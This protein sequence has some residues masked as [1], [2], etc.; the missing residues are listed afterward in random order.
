MFNAIAEVM[1]ICVLCA[2]RCLILTPRT[3]SFPSKIH[4]PKI[5]V[6]MCVG[7]RLRLFI[8]NKNLFFAKDKERSCIGNGIIT[9]AVARC[10]DWDALYTRHLGSTHS[11]YSFT[12]SIALVCIQHYYFHDVPSAGRKTNKRKI[13]GRKTIEDRRHRH[14][15][16]VR[17]AQRTIDDF[18]KNA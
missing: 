4:S 12:L 10:L 5:V 2:P 13:D 18:G 6:V 17:Q 9:V 8:Q 16:A 3:R 15:K 1:L 7:A 11:L 14:T